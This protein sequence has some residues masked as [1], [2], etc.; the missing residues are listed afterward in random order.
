MWDTSNAIVHQL[1][2][3]LVALHRKEAMRSFRISS[4]VAYIV[5]L[6]VGPRGPLG[7][8]NLSKH[9]LM[10]RKKP[11]CD[12]SSLSIEHR[13]YYHRTAHLFVHKIH[14]VS[15]IIA[16]NTISLAICT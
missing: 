2:V 9:A 15:T 11:I 4:L 7:P 5:S 6:T 16:S 3:S 1:L 14:I 12:C 8:L 10:S 13:S